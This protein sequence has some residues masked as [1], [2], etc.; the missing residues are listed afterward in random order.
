MAW[1]RHPPARMT[2]PAG[3]LPTNAVPGSER[4]RSVVWRMLRPSGG[5][6][7]HDPPRSQAGR[8]GSHQFPWV[9]EGQNGSVVPSDGGWETIG[10]TAA[11]F[12][13]L[14]ATPARRPRPVQ[15]HRA[16]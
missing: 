6:V 15:Y 5:G 1:A 3:L 12:G 8:K 16:L 10:T 9:G 13:D 7:T 2:S 11:P 14:R 4:G